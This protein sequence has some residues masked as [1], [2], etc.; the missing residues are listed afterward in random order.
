[1]DTR[2]KQLRK[3]LNLSQNAFGKR[4]GVTA[5]GISKI[6]SGNRNLTEQMQLMISNEFQVNENWLRYGDGEMFKR[7]PPEVIGQL[8]QYYRLDEMDQ[9]IILE[10][11]RLDENKRSIIKEYIMRIAYESKESA[12]LKDGN[13]KAEVLRC[14]EEADIKY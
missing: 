6:E 14:A 10:Y 2:V 1:L 11:A 5:A 12:I 9:R 7:K 3:A 13:S 8:A 4:L